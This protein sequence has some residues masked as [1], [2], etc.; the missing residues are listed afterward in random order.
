MLGVMDVFLNKCGFAEGASRRRWKRL[1][2]K[3]GSVRRAGKG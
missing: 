1:M 3:G 2:R